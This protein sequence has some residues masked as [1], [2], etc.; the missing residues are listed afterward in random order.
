MLPP[1]LGG[2]ARAAI[3]SAPAIIITCYFFDH[4]HTWG[5]LNISAFLHVQYGI[6][7][8]TKFKRPECTRFHLRG[9]RCQNFPGGACARNS[10]EK[11]V[12]RS[13][14]GRYRAHIATV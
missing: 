5:F 2:C 10:L 6:Q 12:V 1:L 14:D 9:L 3:A 11:C 13:P 8:F 4:C 7:A